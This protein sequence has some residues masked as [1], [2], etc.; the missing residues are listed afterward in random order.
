M[1]L[2]WVCIRRVFL[3]LVLRPT[4][5]SGPKVY[6]AE[7]DFASEGT[8]HLHMDKSAAVNIM[9]H[10]STSNS[11]KRGG[12]RWEIWPQTS[13]A[14]LSRI[15]SPSSSEEECNMGIPIISEQSYVPEEQ[16]GDQV[17]EK[18][19]SFIQHPGDAVFI[20][21]GCPHQV[22]DH[23]FILSRVCYLVIGNE[24]WKLH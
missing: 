17:L 23:D 5:L 2:T 24:S 10:S 3:A 6:I 18:A 1:C 14:P 15:L 7:R 12:A 21:P 8:T 13:I 19:W 22:C 4:Y 11:Q 20:P 16:F 9:L